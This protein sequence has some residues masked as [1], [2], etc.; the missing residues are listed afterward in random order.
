MVP[1]YTH[2]L[3]LPRLIKI[4]KISLSFKNKPVTSIRHEK[5]LVS[6]P[7]GWELCQIM[8]WT[9]L[10]LTSGF[11][12]AITLTVPG[13]TVTEARVAFILC[14]LRFCL[15]SAATTKQR[16]SLMLL[17]DLWEYLC[18]DKAEEKNQFPPNIF[19]FLGK[20]LQWRKYSSLPLWQRMTRVQSK[21]DQASCAVRKHN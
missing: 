3:Y 14:C 5:Q 15:G 21:W 12:P 11:I 10:E 8:G 2:L 4:I 19:S 20:Q 7:Q 6:W 18:K 16:S 17:W 1:T 9:K 13:N